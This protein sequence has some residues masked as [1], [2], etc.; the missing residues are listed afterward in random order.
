MGVASQIEGASLVEGLHNERKRPTL[1]DWY[2]RAQELEHREFLDSMRAKRRDLS[3][4][5]HSRIIRTD[6]SRCQYRSDEY[7]GCRLRDM[8][9]RILLCFTTQGEIPSASQHPRQFVCDPR[10]PFN[11]AF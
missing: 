10:I 8:L 7:Y 6:Q 1:V 3:C 4:P 11:K 2:E 9:L 5:E